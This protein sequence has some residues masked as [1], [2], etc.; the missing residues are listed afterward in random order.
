MAPTW[1]G[2]A[3]ISKPATMDGKS[4]APLL[5]DPWTPGLPTSVAAHLVELGS[6]KQYAAGWRDGVLVEYY[7]VADNDKCMKGCNMTAFDYRSYPQK[8]ASCVY[9]AQIVHKNIVPWAKPP[10]S[11]NTFISVSLVYNYF[12][13][14]LHSLSCGVAAFWMAQYIRLLDTEPNSE[15]WGGTCC[16]TDCYP[17]ESLANNF[18]G[19]RSMEGSRLDLKDLFWEG[20]HS[21]LLFCTLP[22]FQVTRYSHNASFKLQDILTLFKCFVI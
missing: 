10:P 3:G 21:N 14:V 5:V 6:P 7:F 12:Y 13:I 9:V 20:G 4:L 17:T 18:I 19:L 11:P 22:F 15:C 8:D 2:L 1:L 16:V